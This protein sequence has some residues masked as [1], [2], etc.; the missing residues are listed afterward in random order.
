MKSEN[1]II[2]KYN[3]SIKIQN[4]NRIIQTLANN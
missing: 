3:K 2:N 1:K 4:Y